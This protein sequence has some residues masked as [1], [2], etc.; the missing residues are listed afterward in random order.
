MLDVDAAIASLVSPGKMSAAQWVSRLGPPYALVVLHSI[1]KVGYD[2]GMFLEHDA[3][4]GP[5]RDPWQTA[6]P[7]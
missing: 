7:S 1:S 2:G 3:V 4:R 6:R 5:R